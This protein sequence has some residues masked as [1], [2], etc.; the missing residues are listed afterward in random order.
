[1]RELCKHLVNPMRFS[2]KQAETCTPNTEKAS[3]SV[4]SSGFSLH[5]MHHHGVYQMFTKLLIMALV[6]CA[7]SMVFGKTVTPLKITKAPKLDGKLDEPFWKQAKSMGDFY[8]FKQDEEKTQDT[9]VKIAYDNSW[10]YFG[11]ICKNEKLNMLTP[12]VQG[13]A[14]EAHTDDSVE[15]FIDPG[16]TGKN[17]LQYKL[18]YAGAKGESRTVNKQSNTAWDEPWLAAVD[19]QPNSWSAEMAIPLYVLFSES[20][21]GPWTINICR[22][23]LILELD[24]Y[25]VILSESREHSSLARVKRKFHEPENFAPLAKLD[26]EK[27][28]TPLMAILRDVKIYPYRTENGKKCL[29]YK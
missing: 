12:K 21:A 7:G 23:K 10:L 9:E 20:G 26:V 16:N 28:Q 4:R 1:M 5:V 3:S 15:I 22:N 24:Q 25:M 2:G 8:I 29:T 19:V 11:F 14:E 27:T 17:Y 13:R 6:F 18:S